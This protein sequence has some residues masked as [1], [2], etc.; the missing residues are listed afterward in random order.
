MPRADVRLVLAAGRLTAA[1]LP[2][3]GG[4]LVDLEIDGRPVL[5]RTP[6]A[7]DVVPSPQAAP[8][9][10][11]WVERWRGGWQVCLPSAGQPDPGDGR[12]GFHG[13]ASQAPWNVESASD[14]SV[15]LSWSDAD[16][17]TA[18]RRWMLADDEV[19]ALT[20]LANHGA[21]TRAVTVAEHLVLGGQLLA[22]PLTLTTDARA[23]QPLDYAGRPDGDERPWPGDEDARWTRVDELTPA[24]VGGLVRA[25]TVTVSGVH[26]EAVVS[27]EGLPHA[28]VWEELGVTTDPPWHGAVH[29]LGIEPSSVPH[30]AGTAAA[31]ATRLAPGESLSWRA[32]LAVTGR[33]EADT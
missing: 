31:D 24:R 16:G 23:L 2:D 25:T 13:A 10:E 15:L 22:G 33:T 5:A 32:T 6:W 20:T 26:G 18:E 7:D 17:L 21:A 19:V 11:T 12:Q 8:D 14:V 9:E 1:V 29:A 28:L 3:E 4:V 27:W 30:G